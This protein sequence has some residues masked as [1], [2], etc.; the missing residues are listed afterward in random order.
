MTE[1][2]Q[3]FCLPPAGAGPSL[4]YP[5]TLRHRDRLKIHPVALPGHESRMAE[6][7]PRSLDELADL[8]AAELA[9]N[10]R[11]RYAMFGYSM[12][13]VLAYE[14]G[15]RWARRGFPAPEMV[16]ILACNPPD[17]LFDG[18][19]PL[20]TM[21]NTA[22]WQAVTDL[23]GMP[24]E[25]L[26][27]AEAR[28]LFEPILRNDFRICE[29]YQHRSDGARLNCLAHAFIADDDGMVDA[30]TAAGWYAFFNG[31]FTLHTLRGKHMLE[32]GKLDALLDRVTSLW[33]DGT[34]PRF[35]GVA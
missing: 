6:P 32:R 4:F 9:P 5:W 15:R 3:L 18:R 29:A 10:L 16:F 24:K 2:P 33:L 28:T 35:A 13:A 19:E 34:R 22:F 26:E 30:E 20:H 12:G 1:L 27:L 31:E 21:E 14:L 23:G 8:L 7:P 11:G 25:I 17:R